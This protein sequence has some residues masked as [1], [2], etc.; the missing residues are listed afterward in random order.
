MPVYTDQTGR[1]I[2]IVRTPVRIVSLV[3][4]QTEL[5]ADLGLDNQVIGITRFCKHPG[6]WFQT[7]T[8][9]GGTKSIDLQKILSLEP[10]LI[11]AN[12]EENN[13]EQIE[14]LAGRFPVWVSDIGNLEQALEM[15]RQFG[16]IV[17]RE[18]RANQICQE[19]RERFSDLVI[20]VK[21]IRTA[22]LIWQDP[23]MTV[24]A[25]TF[26]HAMMNA[27]GLENVFTHKTRYP[28]T[29]PEELKSLDCD[30]LLLASEP[31]PFRES[32]INKFKQ[33]LPGIK[34]CLA[35]GEIFSWYGS[36]LLQAPAY[37]KI[38]RKQVT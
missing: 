26:I 2:S 17:D 20:Q 9:I 35:D 33:A 30:L 10:D 15:I 8:R 31:Y 1:K 25:D 29:S 3:P 27:A 13:R 12:K 28:L 32:H 24:G 23:L 38:L 19:I 5:L 6:H 37:F 16:L 22:Y 4:S 14:D 21:K 7:K 36:R 11:L 18:C 34:I